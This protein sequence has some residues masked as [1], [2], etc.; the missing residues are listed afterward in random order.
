MITTAAPN[1]AARE[2]RDVRLAQIPWLSWLIVSAPCDGIK[3]GRVTLRMANEGLEERARC[4]ASARWY[5]QA[6][7]GGT[8][9]TGNYCVRHLPFVV[10]ADEIARL[11]QWLRVHPGV[12]DQQFIPPEGEI[13]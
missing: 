5:Y 9:A 1:P 10:Y 12:F 7:P 3:W 2:A 6:L 4:R 8:A 13:T 11:G